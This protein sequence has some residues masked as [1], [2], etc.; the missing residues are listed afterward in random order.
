MAG[1]AGETWVEQTSVPSAYWA[2]IASSS[3]GVQI[4]AAQLKSGNSSTGGIIWRTCDGG[5]TWAPLVSAGQARWTALGLSSDGYKVVAAGNGLV[6]VSFDSGS[7]WTEQSPV[8][9]SVAALWGGVS[10]LGQGSDIVAAQLLDTSSLDLRPINIAHGGKPYNLVEMLP[11]CYSRVNPINDTRYCP[12][13]LNGTSFTDAYM[14]GLISSC[15]TSAVLG[16]KILTNQ[17]VHA[18]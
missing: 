9:G 17:Q 3:D 6:K 15:L 4:M 13:P 18:F 10:F 11:D 16:L 8:S 5:S 1:D 7:S 14:V 2:A 12:P